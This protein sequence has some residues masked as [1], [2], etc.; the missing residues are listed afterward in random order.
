MILRNSIKMLYHIKNKVNITYTLLKTTMVSLKTEGSKS[1]EALSLLMK[2]YKNKE[3][4]T[5]EE[6]RFIVQQAK[7]IGKLS[8]LI[9]FVVLPGSPITIPILYKVSKKLNI[10]LTPSAFKK[11]ETKELIEDTEKTLKSKEV[12][13][14]SLEKELEILKLEKNEILDKSNLREMYNR[15][16]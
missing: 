16:F 3:K 8:L 14:N 10:D 11:L 2:K 1:K 12:E 4:L 13:L 15:K 9:P 7:D 6:T 5:E